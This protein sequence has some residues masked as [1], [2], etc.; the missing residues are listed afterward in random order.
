[1]GHPASAARADSTVLGAEAAEKIALLSVVAMCGTPSGSDGGTLYKK[2][3]G[4]Y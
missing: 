1:M 4:L 3:P 2:F